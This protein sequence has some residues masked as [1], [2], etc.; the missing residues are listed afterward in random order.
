M[1]A[2]PRVPLGSADGFSLVEV[3]VAVGLM[4]TALTTLAS[5]FAFPSNRISHP[6]I[7]P[8]PAVLA[9]QKLEELRADAWESYSGQPSTGLDYVDLEGKVVGVGTDPSGRG[10]YA[11]RW[12]IEPLPADP[13]NA[14]IIQVEAGRKNSG[15]SPLDRSR[16]VT[17]KTRK[18]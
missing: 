11:R 4:A 12:S 2:M 18:P 9:Q 3:L 14:V 15:L 5:L 8:M 13:G 17:V 10:V 6:G 1:V 16:V 7:E